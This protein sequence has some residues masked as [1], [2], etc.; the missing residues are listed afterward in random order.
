LNVL[1]DRIKE[2]KSNGKTGEEYLV[3]IEKLANVKFQKLY[4]NKEVDQEE[5]SDG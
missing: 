2:N 1:G 3:D 4:I 5:E